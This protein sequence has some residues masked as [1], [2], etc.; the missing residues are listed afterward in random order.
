MSMTK[1]L[2]G[3]LLATPQ[4][5]NLVAGGLVINGQKKAQ[6][7]LESRV[8]RAFFLAIPSCHLIA[9]QESQRSV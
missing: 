8:R 4:W 9:S 5:G 6:L 1:N 7:E 3:G 2:A